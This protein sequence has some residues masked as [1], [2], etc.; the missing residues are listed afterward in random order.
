M[1]IKI[2]YEYGDSILLHRIDRE[3][4]TIEYDLYCGDSLVGSNMCA[5]YGEGG[6]CPFEFNE[7]MI[8]GD[9]GI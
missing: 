1:R 4:K 5:I 9:G 3:T 2:N 6:C 8:E 7:E